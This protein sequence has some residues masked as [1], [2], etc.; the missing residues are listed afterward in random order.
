MNIL[1]TRIIDTANSARKYEIWMESYTCVRSTKKTTNENCKEN[2][3]H[4]DVKYGITADIYAFIRN[5]TYKN[6]SNHSSTVL[7]WHLRK[8][9]ESSY[10]PQF[11]LLRSPNVRICIKLR[12]QVIIEIVGKS[13][14]VTRGVKLHV[15]E[16]VCIIEH[17]YIYIRSDAVTTRFRTSI[18]GVRTRRSS[19]PTSLRS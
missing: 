3:T 1:L 14:N 10:E 12:S 13:L 5:V 11:L 17:M 9:D 15:V 16:D 2:T 19:R 6:L 7:G 8:S 18:S 4:R